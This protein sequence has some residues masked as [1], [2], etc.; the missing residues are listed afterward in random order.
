MK[1]CGKKNRSMNN[2]EINGI[3]DIIAKAASDNRISLWRVVSKEDTDHTR[4]DVCRAI[5]YDVWFNLI[6]RHIKGYQTWMMSGSCVIEEARHSLTGECNISEVQHGHVISLS[7]CSFYVKNEPDSFSIGPFREGDDLNM[8][9]TCFV[10]STSPA[11]ICHLMSTLNLSIPQIDSAMQDMMSGFVGE[12]LEKKKDELSEQMA[13]GLMI[14]FW[15][16][17]L[18]PRGISCDASYT[19]GVIDMTLFT[20]KSIWIMRNMEDL[21]SELKDLDEVIDRM[22]ADEPE[23]TWN[24]D[25]ID[26][27]EMG[28]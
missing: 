10:G 7:N 18:M 14:G 17:Y 12:A 26:L 8:V 15:K 4:R 6:C 21:A 23:L 13:R 2:T 22:T 27:T 11:D 19:Q 28:L 20:S 9:K 24:N 5:E 25:V 16:K 1:I 3:S